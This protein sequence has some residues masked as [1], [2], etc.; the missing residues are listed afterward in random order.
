MNVYPSWGTL[1]EHPEIYSS[2]S[3]GWAF[4]ERFYVVHNTVPCHGLPSFIFKMGTSTVTAPHLARELWLQ[5]A[6]FLHDL[7]VLMSPVDLF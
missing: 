6:R 7:T 5:T 2:Q 4:L 3:W 1:V